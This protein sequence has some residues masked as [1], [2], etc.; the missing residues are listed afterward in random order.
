VLG[1]L[2]LKR[3]NGQRF[4]SVVDADDPEATLRDA[5]W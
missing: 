5:Q 4:L 2:Q 3:D 1:S